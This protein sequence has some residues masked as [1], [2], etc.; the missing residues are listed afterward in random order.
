V[1]EWKKEGICY[2]A[3]QRHAEIV[4]AGLHLDDKTKSV[5]TPCEKSEIN[6]DPLDAV[7]ETMYRALVARCNYLAQDRSDIGFAVKELC[8]KMSRPDQGS[9]AGLKRLDRYLLK[10]PRVTT[11]YHYQR[12][13]DTVTV[14]T[15]T[16]FAGCKETRKS[17]SGGVMKLGS[18]TVK[19]WSTTQAVIALSSGE[20]EYYGLVKGG[21]VAIGAKNMLRDLGV[22]VN[23]EL[24]T[25]ASAAKGIASRRG[26]GKVRHIEVQ[27]L[28][29]QEKVANGDIVVQNVNGEDNQSDALTKPVDGS[30]IDR[31]ICDTC[32]EVLSGKHSIALSYE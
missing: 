24:K 5:T 21:G 17:T 16:D 9:W 12:R 28:W 22:S 4:I 3:D 29:L 7:S 13:R 14:W 1:V 19:T 18:H 30:H 10:R 11:N 31:H 25:D 26:T 15:D 6:H 32:Q 8:R 2:E 27:Q 23:I 20:A